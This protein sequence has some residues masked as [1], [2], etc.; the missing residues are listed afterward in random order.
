MIIMVCCYYFYQAIILSVVAGREKDV[1]YVLDHPD[2]YHDFDDC[3]H[4]YFKYVAY[5]LAKRL[6]RVEIARLFDIHDDEPDDEVDMSI[7]TR[8]LLEYRKYD[9]IDKYGSVIMKSE[10]EIPTFISGTDGVLYML[11]Y[12]KNTNLHPKSYSILMIS[13]LMYRMRDT[14]AEIANIINEKGGFAPD[15]WIPF[16]N[17]DELMSLIYKHAYNYKHIKQ[18]TL[19]HIQYHQELLLAVFQGKDEMN[20]AMTQDNEYNKLAQNTFNS[21]FMDQ[22]VDDDYDVVVKVLLEF[23]RYDILDEY[24]DKLIRK[25]CHIPY[26]ISGKD[27]VDYMFRYINARPHFKY[28]PLMK[29]AVMYKM[30]NYIPTLINNITEDPVKWCNY[31]DMMKLVNEYKRC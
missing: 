22:Y 20:L 26:D 19:K 24:G 9:V 30:T 15:L 2:E 31:D 28:D 13:A 25:Q 29:S 11:D 1:K 18:S 7:V 16:R 12:I 5:Y 8:T 14:V 3:G 4:H 27:G 10:M 17:D 23:R 21:V 6:N